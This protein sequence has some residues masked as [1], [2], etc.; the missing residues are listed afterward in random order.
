MWQIKG[1]SYL[2]EFSGLYDQTDALVILV[3]ALEKSESIFDF[4]SLIEA[5]DEGGTLFSGSQIL[6][7]LS[8]G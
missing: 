5:R 1:I 3:Q 2:E 4:D 7:R 8:Q 6:E